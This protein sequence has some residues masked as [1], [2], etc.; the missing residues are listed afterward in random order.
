MA[1]LG[2]RY[3][4][5]DK[6]LAGRTPVIRHRF[7]EGRELFVYE[8]PAPISP[9]TRSRGPFRPP[10]RRKRSRCWRTRRSTCAALPFSRLLNPC[11]RWFRRARRV[12]RRTRRVSHRGAQPG[13]VP[14]G[15]S[16]RIQPLPA[17][18]MGAGPRSGA[19]SDAR[20]SR[21][22]GGALHRPFA[23]PADAALRHAST[24]DAGS[25][26]GAMRKLADRRCAP[27]AGA[28]APLIRAPPNR[29]H[30]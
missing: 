2:A 17:R 14:A 27:V 25:R 15:P 20:Q 9:A 18:P 26:I 23:R 3:L 10:T 24:T 21:P 4:L 28:G 29:R 5:H 8:I 16:D 7:V 11:L 12:D 13:Y 19:A 22:G 6:A 30:A 1:L